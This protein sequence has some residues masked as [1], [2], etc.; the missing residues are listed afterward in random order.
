MDTPLRATLQ[1]TSLLI[2]TSLA[3][4][5]AWAQQ[6]QMPGITTPELSIANDPSPPAEIDTDTEARCFSEAVNL[7]GD[8]AWCDVLITAL[9]AKLPP[10]PQADA[11][12]ARGYHNRALLLTKRGEF[13]LAEADL[14]AA[15]RLQPGWPE[16]YLTMGNLRLNQNRFSEA[17]ERF[18]DAIERSTAPA[19]EYFVNRALALRGLGQIELA[20]DDIARAEALRQPLPPAAAV[21]PS[22]TGAAPAGEFR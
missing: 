7:S 16:L 4:A 2:A 8:T 20:A 5:P 19:P 6:S 9:N 1:L 13:E 12:L 22:D 21:S 10:D 11:A 17:L 18:N 15:T 14:V 3:L